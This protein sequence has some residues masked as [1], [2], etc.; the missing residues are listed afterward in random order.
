[1]R[2]ILLPFLCIGLCFIFSCKQNEAVQW[3]PADCPIPT[4]WTS[5][6][7]PENPW[8]S[9]P[10][11]QMARSDWV[12]L[13]GLWD[14][15]IL[16]ETITKA[17]TFQGRILV[18]YPVESAL[19]G[20]KR[21]VGK[22]NKLWYQ[23]I[24]QIPSSWKGQNVLLHIEASDWET[25]LWIDGKFIG[26]HRGGYDPFT[27]NITEFISFN[28]K[29]TLSIS[30]W[31]PTSDGY[32]PR[33]KQIN[34][35]GGIFY[36]SVTG[37]WQTIWL[38]PVPVTFIENFKIQANIDKGSINVIPFIHQA[39]KDDVIEITVLQ[40]NEIICSSS[41]P[42][43][44]KQTLEIPNPKLWFPESPFL[45]DLNIQLIRNEE[46][47]DAVDSYFGLR[48]ISLEKDEEGITRISLNKKFIFQNGPLDQGY[49]PDG[50]YTPPTEKAMVYDLEKIKSF[51]FNML[52]K[53]VKIEPRLFYSWCDR[54]GLL[55]WQDMPNAHGYVGPDKPDLE[56][57]SIHKNQF[58][59]EL[60]KLVKMHW[61]NP[62]IIMWVAFNEGWGQ[63]DTER[64]V[65]LIKNIDQTHLVCNTSGWA[66]RGV[67]DIYDL[68][69][70]PEP[71]PVQPEANRAAVL[72]EFGGL[73]FPVEGH[74]WETKNWGYENMEDT[75]SLIR[76]YAAFYDLVAKFKK[77]PGISACIYTQITDVETETNGLMT[78]DRAIVKMNE[79]QL[80][81]INQKVIIDD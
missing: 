3:Q 81:K 51:G 47:V 66:D 37:I 71:I 24:I 34:K 16:P 79:Q 74:T 60:S 64:I 68:H 11:P 30:V 2:K 54:L 25:R 12:N 77:T 38:E 53:H 28:E 45:Y 67:G 6:V 33:G 76:K 43:V 35:P 70:Y 8:S 42:A 65:G 56:P 59:Y 75:S 49:W 62:S 27:F 48:E 1:M 19:S 14:Y 57:D 80:Y 41:G 17:D 18:P 40:N 13:N 61:N 78:Y 7:N 31:D 15:A 52:R 63:Y 55:V 39:G 29:H 4:Q 9:Y 20:V 21:T 23:R 44:S 5:E 46:I 50:L 32:Q 58:E 26:E 36:T 22:D 10:R 73:G 69:H 72:G